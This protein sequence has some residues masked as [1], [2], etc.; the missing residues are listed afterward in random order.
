[1]KF[2]KERVL[3]RLT[4]LATHHASPYSTLIVPIGEHWQP[5]GKE[6]VEAM[7]RYA[8][9]E[10]KVD[11]RIVPERDRCYQPYDALGS[12][13]NMAY[14]RAMMMG[15][16][17]LM[18][19]DNDIL[20]PPHTLVQLLHWQVPIIAPKV[21][22]PP[23]V[24][25][26]T[27]QTPLLDNDKGLVMVGSVVLSCVLFKT[28][29][30]LPWAVHDFW[31]NALGDDEEYHFTKFYMAGHMPFVD[32]DTQVLCQGAPHFPLDKKPALS[33]AGWIL[34]EFKK[35]PVYLW[36]HNHLAPPIGKW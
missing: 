2:D 31:G 6:A 5:G 4:T 7:A 34:D 15:Y 32:S 35:N 25:F 20:P 13:R 12:M 11:A 14:R 33:I 21:V 30:F 9:D 8:R 26:G 1:M 27:L 10:F 16:E 18:M 3:E 19:V 17:F 28:T 24:P 36:A 22:Y 29:V 23:G